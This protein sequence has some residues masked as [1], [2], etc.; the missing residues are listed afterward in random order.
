MT[1]THSILSKL[2]IEIDTSNND[3]RTMSAMLFKTSLLFM[4]Q[5]LNDSIIHS[6][7]DNSKK[8]NDKCK[9]KEGN[10][11]VPKH[12]QQTILENDLYNFLH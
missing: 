8:N 4:K 12:V 5:L 11:L 9:G 10:V 1:W 7:T 2:K 3:D 6:K